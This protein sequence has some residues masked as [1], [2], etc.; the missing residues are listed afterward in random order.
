MSNGEGFSDPTAEQAIHNVMKKPWGAVTEKEIL[1]I[2]KEKCRYC[3]YSDKN[4]ASGESLSK[5]TC[6]YIGREKHRRG[7]RPDECDKFVRTKKV[8]ERKAMRV[9]KEPKTDG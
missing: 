8:R 7:C 1:Q 5:L 3:K 2:K 4:S 9:K 6:D